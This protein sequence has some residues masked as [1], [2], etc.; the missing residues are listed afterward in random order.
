VLDT[1]EAFGIAVP[2]IFGF[3]ASGRG[4]EAAEMSEALFAGV[5]FGGTARSFCPSIGAEEV[6]V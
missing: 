1:L 6:V 2:L 3:F 4:M 5:T